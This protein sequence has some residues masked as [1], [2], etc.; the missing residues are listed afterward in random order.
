M[1]YK[2]HAKKLERDRLWRERQRNDPEL[3]ARKRA[4]GL[5]YYYRKKAKGLVI[6]PEQREATKRRK[7]EHYARLSLEE[8]RARAVHGYELKKKKREE[9]F[10][11]QLKKARQEAL[12]ALR[13][14]EE[15]ANAERYGYRRI[16]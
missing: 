10:Q 2:D 16:A 1:P 12:R 15:R 7:R 6:T 5:A 8:K 3:L 13:L 11:M 4:H 14:A 9:E